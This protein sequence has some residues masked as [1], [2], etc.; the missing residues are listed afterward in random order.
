MIYYTNKYKDLEVISYEYNDDN[1]LEVVV[2]IPEKEFT[3][4]NLV[5]KNHD[6]AVQLLKNMGL[7]AKTIFEYSDIV[8]EN[9][10]YKQSKEKN[11]TTK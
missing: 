1:V 4:P 11:T 6:I 2:A 3:M 5:F 7:E 9:L 8:A 10:V